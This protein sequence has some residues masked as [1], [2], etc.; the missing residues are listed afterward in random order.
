MHTCIHTCMHAYIHTCIHYIHYPCICIYIYIY[1]YACVY[2]YIYIYIYT[3]ICTCIYIANLHPEGNFGGNQLLDGSISPS[4]L[5][6][7]LAN[8]LHVSIAT[9]HG[10]GKRQAG[11][12][13]PM[14]GQRSGYRN[15]GGS[16]PSWKAQHPNAGEQNIIYIYIYICMCV[17][18]YIYICMYIY[19][20][21]YIEREREKYTTH[22]YHTRALRKTKRSQK[23]KYKC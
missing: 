20:Y 10:G 6:A 12:N 17:Y 16:R 7:V 8:D 14:R 11:V 1:I 3:N 22:A 4:P 23:H 9:S 21:I 15:V 18:I 13:R 19:I 5:C 2:I